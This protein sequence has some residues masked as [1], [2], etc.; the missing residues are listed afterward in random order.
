M[1]IYNINLTD[2]AE[3]LSSEE[4]LIRTALDVC[5]DEGTA[6]R[7]RVEQVLWLL[8]SI[9]DT[10][11]DYN[12]AVTMWKDAHPVK[13]GVRH[14]VFDERGFCREVNLEEAARAEGLTVPELLAK[15][16]EDMRQSAEQFDQPEFAGDCEGMPL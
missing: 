5:D 6:I 9:Q 14:F 4:K 8:R 1:K 11:R 7:A 15:D 13:P 2:L 10:I 16:A 3:M 12:N